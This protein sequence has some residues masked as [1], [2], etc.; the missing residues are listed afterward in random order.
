MAAHLP[1]SG[2]RRGRTEITVLESPVVESASARRPSRRCGT[3]CASS[4][5][6]SATGCAPAARPTRPHAVPDWRVGPNA[7]VGARESSITPSS[8]GRSPS[9]TRTAA[10]ATLKPGRRLHERPLLDEARRHGAEGGIRSPRLPEPGALRREALEATPEDRYAYHMDAA[11]LA[12]FLRK[13]ATG[14][15]VRHVQDH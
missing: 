11:L 1:Q 2:S 14:R 3:R 6:R 9:F 10:Q 15:G 12:E 4:A 8:R 7:G 5:W 13:L